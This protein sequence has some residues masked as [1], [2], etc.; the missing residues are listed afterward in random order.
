MW[1]SII[2]VS[3]VLIVEWEGL[4]V[5]KDDFLEIKSDVDFLLS[6]TGLFLKKKERKKYLLPPFLVYAWRENP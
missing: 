5:G 2:N 1:N 4:D 3:C 6:K